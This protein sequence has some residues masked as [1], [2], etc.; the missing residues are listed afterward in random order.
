MDQ[1]QVDVVGAQAAQ[2]V[3]D[4]A[5]GGLVPGVG[6]PDLGGQED[7]LSRQAGGGDGGAHPLL[8]AIGLGGVDVP[9]ADLE[10]LEHCALGL[11]G[12]GLEDAVPDLRD[13]DAVVDS[14]GGDRLVGHEFSFAVRPRS[15]PTAEVYRCIGD[16]PS[17][18]ALRRPLDAGAARASG[19]DEQRAVGLA[20]GGALLQRDL[21]GL[22]IGA[23]GCRSLPQPT[24]TGRPC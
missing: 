2:G 5:R 6:D 15:Q 19:V 8:V 20:I 12:R 9:V 24:S 14:D 3:I 18:N 1:E 23:C 7:V 22:A 16:R 13:D 4:G 21:A 11:L 17:E 10:G